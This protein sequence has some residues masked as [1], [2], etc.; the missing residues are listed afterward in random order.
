MDQNTQKKCLPKI[1]DA[2]GQSICSYTVQSGEQAKTLPTLEKVWEFLNR[3]GADRKSLLV[4]L[5]GGVLCDMGGFAASCFKR[6]I[7]FI[8]IP[9]TLLAQ[10]DASV[11]GKTG[12]NFKIFKNEIGTFSF[13]I[14]VI[15]DTHFLETL[16]H[17]HLLSGF[18]EM[19]KHALISD[20]EYFYRLR[21]MNLNP[22]QLDFA[23][24]LPLVEHSVRIK[25]KVVLSDPLET[26]LRKILNFGHTIGHAFESY[27]MGT[28]DEISHGRAVAYGM[29]VE[30]FLSEKKSG[31]PVDKLKDA[32][33]YINKVYGKARITTKDF[34]PLIN[35]MT[36]DKK[37]ESAKINFSLLNDIGLPVFD[38][39][40]TT[41]EIF[42]GLGLYLRF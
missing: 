41:E 13:P 2:F 18:A 6:G 39:T 10:V 27:F 12:V 19:L 28:T 31:L 4:N 32:V 17:E 35:L 22:A 29:A 25:E 11:G 21:E 24:L 5:G 16:D 8:H 42:D 33:D 23:G 9:T 7:D 15:I 36:H 14:K 38:Q 40:A 37:N 3:E 30:L 20:Q 1:K 34:E 26:G